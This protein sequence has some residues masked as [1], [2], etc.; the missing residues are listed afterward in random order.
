MID[1]YYQLWLAII[2]FNSRTSDLKRWRNEILSAK[3]LKNIWIKVKWPLHLTVAVD[4]YMRDFNMEIELWNWKLS[5][6]LR[7]GN[8][9][10]IEIFYKSGIGIEE[11]DM[12]IGI[13][14]S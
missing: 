4:S 2:S 10:G 3:V 12:G 9:I 6:C 8:S 11:S 14:H 5:S 13:E 1:G 7:K